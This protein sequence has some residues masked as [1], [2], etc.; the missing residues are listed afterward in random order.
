MK[1][2]EVFENLRL[3]EED[4][5]EL[6][7]FLKKKVNPVNDPIALVAD[8]GNTI[9][10]LSSSRRSDVSEGEFEDEMEKEIMMENLLSVASNFRNKFYNKLGSNNRR[11]SSKPRAYED[12][13]RYIRQ[14]DRYDSNTLNRYDYKYD[15][16]YEDIYVRSSERKKMGDQIVERK[17]IEPRKAGKKQEA[18][19]TCFKCRTE[20]HFERERT[21][22]MTK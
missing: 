19:A 8:K 6:V 7:G 5:V 10:Y 9:R 17:E 1:L 18:P 4:V 15:R 16:Q 22:K 20:G 2:Y 13:D 11:M 12:K 21:T 3:Y 14:S